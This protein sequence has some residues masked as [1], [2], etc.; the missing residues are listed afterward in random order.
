MSES[1][2]MGL[3]DK[4]IVVC[5]LLLTPMMTFGQMMDPNKAAARAFTE[6]GIDQ[7]L[8]E[9]LPLDLK[10]RNEKGETVELGEYFHSKPVILSLVYYKCPM[11]CTQVLNGMVETFR[12]MKMTAGTEFEIVTVSI[13][14]RETPAMAAEKKEVYVEE[15]GRANVGQSW[16]F[17]VGDSVSIQ[18]LA[19]A[20]GFRFVYD[21]PTK[22]FAHAS[23]IMVATP[24]GRIA[25]YLYGIEYGAKDLTF[26]LMDAAQGKIGSVVDKI[27]LLCYHYD[28]TTGKYGMVVANLLR[29]GGVLTVVVIAAYMFFN[30]RRER[31]RVVPPANIH[32]N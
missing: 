6:V 13:D 5:A 3:M 24:K 4:W 12:T 15:Y 11:L 21:P 16:H 30:I 32:L 22:Q 26:S 8:N 23:G 14:H 7:K 27:L 20:V 18:K 31:K 19:D 2:M 9:Q 28:P 17:L 29:A 10:F 1:K 25:R